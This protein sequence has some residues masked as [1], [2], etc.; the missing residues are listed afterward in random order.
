MQPVALEIDVAMNEE[1]KEPNPE[2][3]GDPIDGD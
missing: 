3:M 1:S 2:I